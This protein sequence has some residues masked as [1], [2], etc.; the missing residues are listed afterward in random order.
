MASK[1]LIDGKEVGGVVKTDIVERPTI[2]DEHGKVTLATPE[3][4]MLPVDQLKLLAKLAKG[5]LVYRKYEVTYKEVKIR[6]QQFCDWRDCWAL[7]DGPSGYCI[8]H[9]EMANGKG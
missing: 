3:M 9:E 7:A 4:E 6:S 1:I 2:V 5:K 8:K